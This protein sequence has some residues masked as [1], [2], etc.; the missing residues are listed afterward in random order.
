MAASTLCIQF[1]LQMY[2]EQEMNFDPLLLPAYFASEQTT[3][4]P[5]GVFQL[6]LPFI[7]ELST[8]WHNKV[9]MKMLYLETMVNLTMGN[10]TRTNNF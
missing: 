2:G 3:L 8:T 4:Q 7:T 10:E 1:D 5:T 9:S 6:T